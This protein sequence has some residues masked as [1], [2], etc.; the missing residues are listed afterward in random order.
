MES[1]STNHYLHKKFKKQLTVN[2]KPQAKQNDKENNVSSRLESN[3]EK[4]S[5]IRCQEESKSEEKALYDERFS[6]NQIVLDNNIISVPNQSTNQHSS[7]F[8]LNSIFSKSSIS[9]ESPKLV[10]DTH[11]TTFA[12]QQSLN[13]CISYVAMNHTEEHVP[14][15]F[16][17]KFSE[18]PTNY[19]ASASSI[20]DESYPKHSYVKSENHNYQQPYY[21][22]NI[23]DYSQKL[24]TEEAAESKLDDFQPPPDKNS[25]GKYVC[26][27]CNLVCSKPSVLQK[28]IR[29]HTNE[30]PY[31]CKSCGFSFKTRSNLYKH[32]RSRTHANRV[33]GIKTQ[34]SN[35]E[36][37]ENF[38]KDES[39]IPKPYK[40]RFH[41]TKEYIENVS[42]E[43]IEDDRPSPRHPA[44]E[45]LS[46]HINEIIIKNKNIVNDALV[47]RRNNDDTNNESG[48]NPSEP[49]YI[50]S[51]SEPRSIDEPLNLTNKNRKRSLSEVTE[52]VIQKSLIKELLLKN[53]SASDMQCP[54]CKMI[55]QTVTELDVHKYRSCKGKLAGAKYARSSSVNVASIL[56]Q[57]KN[58]FDNIPHIQNFSLNSPGPFLG[59]T[60][61]VDSD[62]SKS[63]S[64]DSCN[65]SFTGSSEVSPNYLLSPLPF[66]KEKKGLKLFGGEV[67]IH[68]S[69]ETK[70]FKVDGKDE[71][72]SPET[73]YAGYGENRVIKSS[74][75]SGGTV[76][77]NKTNYNK[78]DIN[79][80]QEV[81]RVYENSLVSPNIDIS[82]LTKS[83]FTFDR[84]VEIDTE[85]VV[86]PN[87]SNLNEAKNTYTSQ[88]NISYKYTNIM[89]FSQKAIQKI[90]PNIKQPIFNA[91]KVHLTKPEV[92]PD[93][94]PL[95][96]PVNVE[97]EAKIDFVPIQK[98]FFQETKLLTPTSNLYNPMKLLVNGKVVRHVPG[99]PGPVVADNPV[100]VIGG[101]VLQY[102]DI[103]CI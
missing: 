25:N 91:T 7:S 79:V 48:L 14:S 11:M 87:F 96:V 85:S 50:N 20:L 92:E 89:D 35:N 62:K 75:Q 1:G 44:S 32:C 73:N 57:N 78:Q 3:E 102:Y 71:K 40:P 17:T 2:P 5:E 69:G 12:N 15:S 34:E 88:T 46:Q 41:T 84:Q 43:N 10:A 63:F 30:R 22:Y 21:Q 90:T 94:L 19:S 93:H 31:P 37:P 4:N 29:A 66:E 82:S 68:S 74:L 9:V 49:L 52:P 16:D 67:K 6:V 61:L 39:A 53:L 45:M 18:E 47:K 65:I 36:L 26:H 97:P 55:F 100:D 103:K 95:I 80:S 33:M 64:F 72:L 28:H 86:R 27:Y 101:N 76:L 38:D 8:P 54:H 51:F 58:A 56:T 60:R 77:T 99:M 23:Q 24:S 81:I 59:K 83:R 13:S 98:K 70:S 42:K